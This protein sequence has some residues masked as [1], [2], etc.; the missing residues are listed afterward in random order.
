MQQQSI[1]D[2]LRS[3]TIFYWALFLS[4]VAVVVGAALLVSNQS[5]FVQDDPAFNTIVSTA[6]MFLL[7]IHAPISYIIPQ[8]MISRIDRIL[9]L[10]QK[11]TQ[12]RTALLIRFA[13]MNSASFLIAMAFVVTGNI[14]LMYLQVIVML[15]FLAYKPGVLKIVVDLDLDDA[16]RNRLNE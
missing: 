4:S 16:E 13:A 1:K 9:P 15:F 10:E 3:I 14:N 5:E 6:L 12:Y 2:I 8:K 7:I 11:L